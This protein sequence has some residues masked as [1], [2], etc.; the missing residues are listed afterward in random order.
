MPVAELKHLVYLS[1]GEK[2][3]SEVNA[4]DEVLS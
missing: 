2:V 4:E 3:I 1:M